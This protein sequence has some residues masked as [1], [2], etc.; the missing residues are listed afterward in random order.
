VA[1]LLGSGAGIVLMLAAAPGLGRGLAATP[2]PN[3]HARLQT[4]GLYRLVRHPMYSGLLLL[5]LAR[6]VASGR[7]LVAVAGLLLVALLNIKARWEERRLSER[8]DA[9]PA[10]A[11]R[12]ARFF[13]GIRFPRTRNALR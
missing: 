13:P 10:Y 12:T 4:T 9:Y 2:V 6:A 8:F 3:R 5:A 11:Q 7:T 1:G